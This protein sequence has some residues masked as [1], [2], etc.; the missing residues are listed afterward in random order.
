VTRIVRTAYHC[1]RPPKR[2]QPVAIEVPAVVRAADPAKARRRAQPTPPESTPAISKGSAKSTGK[3]V[4]PLDV[5]VVSTSIKRAALS[6]ANDD[7]K[8]AIVTAKPKRRLPDGPPLPMELPLSRKP[9]EREDDYKRL[10]AAMAR[11][12]RGE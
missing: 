4:K 5:A 7:H 12:L 6:A 3:P 9:V 11:R 1:K 10:K 2:K 8:P